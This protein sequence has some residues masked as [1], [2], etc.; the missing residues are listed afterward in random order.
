MKRLLVRTENKGLFYYQG[1]D[2]IL[3][4]HNRL[5]GLI[6]LIGDCTNI[7]GNC[8]YLRGNCSLLVGDCTGLRGDCTGIFGNCTGIDGNFDECELTPGDRVEGIDI[9][10]LIREEK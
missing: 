6:N 7:S 3:G 5:W 1:G 9:K 10:Q 4:P 8:G 2:M